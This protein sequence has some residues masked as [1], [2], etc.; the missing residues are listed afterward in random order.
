MHENKNEIL[1]MRLVECNRLRYP[2]FFEAKDP[3]V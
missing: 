3:R 1:N 2:A